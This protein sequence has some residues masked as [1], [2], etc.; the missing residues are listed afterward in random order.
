MSW[1]GE[2]LDDL[3]AHPACGYLP[4]QP[5]ATEPTALVALAL[6]AHERNTEARV[7]L[8][9][10]AQAQNDDGS[11]GVRKEESAPGWPTSLAVVAWQLIDATNFRKPVAAACSWI[12]K[13]HGELLERN[14]EMG[15]NTQ[16]EGW[17]WVLSTHSWLEP[18]AL[19]VLALKAAGLNSHERTRDGVKLVFDRILPAGGCNYGNT[20]VLGQTLRPHVQPTG[21]AMLSLASESDVGDRKRKSLAYLE[22]VINN[23]TTASSLGW[24]TLGL[25]ANEVD[26]PDRDALLARQATY[27]ADHDRGAHKRALLALAALGQDSPLIAM[28]KDK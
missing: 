8:D 10:L 21:I 28:A 24:A 20:T 1:L 23:R 16:L 12:L 6:H 3:A 11:L 2:I 27:V 4:S 22:R 18:S 25:A 13:A 17:P 15:H 5:P 9:Y 19:Q 14:P 26:L 7:A